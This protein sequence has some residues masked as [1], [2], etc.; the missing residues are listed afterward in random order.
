MEESQNEL[1]R[2]SSG[3]G[4]VCEQD[5]APAMFAVFGLQALSNVTS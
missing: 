5:S 3:A 4:N 2:E 1:A